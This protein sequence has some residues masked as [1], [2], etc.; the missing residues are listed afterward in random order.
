VRIAIPVL[1]DA[2]CH[3]VR[4]YDLIE[5]KPSSFDTFSVMAHA[6]EKT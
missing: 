6:D 4:K 1:I 3:I 2:G 5:I